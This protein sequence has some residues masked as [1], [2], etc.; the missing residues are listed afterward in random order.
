MKQWGHEYFF[1]VADNHFG[2]W[3]IVVAVVGCGNVGF[4]FRLG[5]RVRLGFR[6]FL[7]VLEKVL[8]KILFSLKPIGTL[9]ALKCLALRWSYRNWGRGWSHDLVL[10]GGVSGERLRA[11]REHVRGLTGMSSQMVLEVAAIREVFGTVGAP[12][13]SV[14]AGNHGGS[15]HLKLGKL[16]EGLRPIGHV[17][18]F[19]HMDP[20][21]L[22]QMRM[23]I[24]SLRAMRAR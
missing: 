14:R 12:E 5:L 18:V 20:N 23:M 6:L 7:D 17:R 1:W 21:V 15:L 16:A 24:E 3:Y 10:V 2:T 8:L 4:W 22:F 19:S 11:V 13:L 9:G